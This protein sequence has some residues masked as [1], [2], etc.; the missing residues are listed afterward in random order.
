MLDS[1]LIR[2]NPE[3]VAIA[4]AKRGYVLDVERIKALEEE[5]KAI[6]T[7]TEML[8]TGAQYPLQKYW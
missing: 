2:T 4:L 7:K 6:Q 3:A 1:K 8:Q 5:R